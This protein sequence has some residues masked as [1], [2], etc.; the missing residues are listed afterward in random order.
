MISKGVWFL[1][2]KL[3]A[4]IALLIAAAM[5][6]GV[7]IGCQPQAAPEPEKPVAT[8]NGVE[9]SQRDLDTRVGIYKLFYGPSID[10][11]EIRELLLD[12]LIDEVIIEEEARRLGIEISQE[13]LQTEFGF[14]KEQLEWQMGGAEGAAAGLKDAGLTEDDLKA[15]I[16]IYMLVDDVYEQ[17]TLD[18][19]MPD[20]DVR[21]YYDEFPTQFVEQESISASHILVET[22]EEAQE[23]LGKL[24]SGADF[25]EIAMEHSICPSAFSGGDLGRFGRGMMDATFEAAAYALEVGQLSGIVETE[26]GFHIIRLDARY[27]EKQ[28][29]FDEVQGELKR[30][31]LQEVKNDFFDNYVNELQQ[32]ANIVR[33]GG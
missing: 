23:V 7:F 18:V 1:V 13:L 8:V 10:T 9:I 24:S 21:K 33:S 17:V 25:G 28:L 4:A 31:L 16:A 5:L 12:Q 3:S 22:Q 32:G 11:P 2:K 19:D 6:G 26:F 29:S 14:F 27:P 15:F 20:E 30:M